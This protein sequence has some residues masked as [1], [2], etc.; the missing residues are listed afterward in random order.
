M[1]SCNFFEMFSRKRSVTICGVVFAV[2]TALFSQT[3]PPTNRIT[4]EL[5]S[6][7]T[8]TVSGT[9]HPLTR[10]AT[11]LGEVNS[12][13]QM[14][15]LV[16]NTSLSAVQQNDL[17]SLLEALQ[18][19]SSPQ[20]HQWLTQQQYGERFGLTDADL[21]TVTGWLTGQGFTI[22]S[23]ASSRN[24]IYFSGNAGQVELAFQTQLHNY[25]LDGKT[26]FAN[27]TE[28][29]VPAAIGSV[30]LNVRGL[31]N[32]RPKA[33]ISKVSQAISPQF[34]NYNGNHFLAPGDWA[35]IYDVT[36]IYN[37]GYTGLGAHVGVVGQTYAPQ[38][39]IDHFR[40]AA[41]LSSTKINYQCISSADCT[42]A[43]GTS[44]DGDLSES[45]LDIE[46]AGGIAKNATV[47][48]IYASHSD[49]TLDVYDALQYAIQT[50]TVSG[51]V[52]PVLSMSYE[53]CEQNIS[54]TDASY[55]LN[56]AQQANSQGQ[57][58][59]V[60]AGDSGAAGCDPHGES[61]YTASVYGL[62]VSVPAD[63][64]GVTG[65]GGTILGDESNPSF[66]W[67]S[68]TGAAD[69]ALR[70]IPES[71]WN[72][73]GS[74]GLIAGG[75]GVS[76]FFPTPIWQAV[77][78]NF[79][80]T[81]GRFVPDISF[82]A[83]WDHDAYLVCSQIDN[84][85]TYGT[86]CTDGF[87][88][89]LDY[90]WYSGGTSASAPSFAGMLTLLTQKYGHLGNVN[91][92]LYNL[93]SNAATYA[94]VFHDITIGN[95]IVPCLSS[96]VGCVNGQLGYQATTGYDLVTG[97][98][99]LD[100]G[101]LYSALASASNLASA[102]VT[103]TA[104]PSSLNMGSTTTLAATVTSAT[105]GSISGTITF[106][107]GTTVL[108][109]VTISNSTA[110]LTSVAITPANGFTAGMSA[111]I[112]ASYSG[113]MTFQA[114]SGSTTMTLAALPTTTTTVTATPNPVMIGHTTTLTMTVTSAAG[115]AINGTATFN[116]GTTSIG[117]APVVNGTATLNNE[118][119]SI[120]NGF[121]VGSDT[122]TA[123]YG[124]DPFNYTASSG[125]MPL[126]VLP[127][128]ATTTTLTALPSS[129]VAGGTTT[130]T[131]TVA[132]A[133]A[134][135]PTGTVTFTGYYGTFGTATVSGGTATLSNL[136]VNLGAFLPGTNTITAT[137]S[138]DANFAASSGTTPMTVT[139][140]PTTTTVSVSPS[141]LMINNAT[142]SLSVTVS[143][144]GS[145]PN[146][147]GY[148][149]FQTNNSQ[150]GGIL[151][152]GSG[153]AI[154]NNVPVSAANGFIVGT[155]TITANYY[156][157]WNFAASSGT[158]T[159][160]VI[161]QPAT[162]TVVTATPNSVTIGGM[163]TLTANVTST[164]PGTPTGT[165]NFPSGMAPLLSNG[166][167]TLANI[168]VNAA[169]GFAGGTY[170]IRAFYS[171]DAN[172]ASSSG[173]TTMTVVALP[174]TTTVT[175]TPS[176]VSPGGTT[177]VTAAVSGSGG[178]T[179]T[180]TVT[181]NVG[182]TRIYVSSLSNGSFNW[183]LPVGSN[184]GFSGGPNT[185]TVN[186]SGDGNFLPSQASMTVT[187]V[188]TYTLS[189]ASSSVS[190]SDG[191]NAS[192]ALNLT[193]NGYVGTVTF[194][195]SVS[196]ANGSASAISASATP[197]MITSNGTGSSTLTITT[198]ASAKNRAPMPPWKSVGTV[199][200]CAVLLGVPFTQRRKRALTVLMTALAISVMGILL[201]C[202]G[203][204][205]STPTPAPA[206]R[207]Y[208]LTV[209][210]T[211]TGTVTNPAPLV[212]TLTV[213]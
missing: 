167:A 93:A 17:N 166:T 63:V 161:P 1:H 10:R 115:G 142:I 157:N 21:A 40:S 198:T 14:G 92:T 163:T 125:T 185:V 116:V 160:T 49:P 128:S 134:G 208:T 80:G 211:G 74:D 126:T 9:V 51:A 26:H 114:S 212:I 201:S 22:K 32:F 171:G 103:V 7:A 83:S 135:T 113:N 61:T 136:T 87:L 50:Y 69:T 108:G 25:E 73:S 77:P 140:I 200:F 206:A 39:D 90:F 169:N 57:T 84:S 72:E 133:A 109:V 56:L 194:T 137:Y 156:A 187:E 131:A 68:T 138:G 123:R 195:T 191:T 205:N 91:P 180:G 188:P 173:S 175:A 97:L 36:S 122:I 47:D 102:T 177:T 6:G 16:L 111:L 183:S 213:P 174:S 141:S 96:A 24:A 118:A 150:I 148:V 78:D 154:L 124:G 104:T 55:Y 41:G 59:V 176:S 146:G 202:G 98:G 117:T 94:T 58:I 2:A 192:V 4:G 144:A 46:W 168:T 112:T 88:S 8:V 52:V 45:D 193:S 65:V 3:T 30:L 132:S 158:T 129:L 210:P 95:N 38:A 64:P 13:M 153:T 127:L 209:T 105:S 20:Y 31:N 28:L 86:T 35:T 18:N 204:G 159:L 89:S 53:H 184:N 143:S 107:N 106:A 33:S 23:V 110:T 42:D 197:V 203:G 182:S 170:S 164:A 162:T 34:T 15:A 151:V 62:S 82:T 100:G 19:P 101:A 37:A 79:T 165:V 70:Y 147:Y 196:T 27:A 29:R 66:Y 179:P 155:N 189:S 207:T 152:P 99:S 75:G 120:A 67:S 43:A 149:Y 119:V 44:S 186:Y 130:F 60:S 71:A 85:A 178:Y 81:A 12:G 139:A 54:A 11:D 145:A 181:L 48:F 190:T 172:F 5:S 76:T 121:S 199:V